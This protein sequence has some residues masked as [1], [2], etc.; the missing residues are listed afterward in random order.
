MSQTEAP[1]T[2]A[3]D[4]PLFE[5]D[6][7]VLMAIASGVPVPSGASL[8][9]RQRALNYVQYLLRGAAKAAARKNPAAVWRLERLRRFSH[10]VIHAL[11]AAW[12]KQPEAK[13]AAKI[14]AL[15]DPSRAPNP[16]DE[17]LLDLI[18]RA[19]AKVPPICQTE[20]IE[21]GREALLCAVSQPPD[22]APPRQP[23]VDRDVD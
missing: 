1:A 4:E 20:A 12:A 5:G 18:R 7:P 9:D 22:V 10:P 17:V 15:K 14:A 16:C 8:I 21:F 6:N 19:R 2:A 3:D 23:A 13:L 11:A